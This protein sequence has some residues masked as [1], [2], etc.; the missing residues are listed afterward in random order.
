MGT[1]LS[2]PELLITPL[3]PGRVAPVAACPVSPCCCVCILS[4]I[5]LLH[6]SVCLLGPHVTLSTRVIPSLCTPVLLADSSSDRQ[7]QPHALLSVRGWTRRA[8][9]GQALQG[10]MRAAPP[11]RMSVAHVRWR[12]AGSLCFEPR[13]GVRVVAVDLTCAVRGG[14]VTSLS[15]PPRPPRPV[16]VINSEAL[17]EVSEPWDCKQLPTPSRRP[18]RCS[19]RSAAQ[20]C[21]GRLGAP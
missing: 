7:T 6:D 3:P 2:G 16:F 1:T 10:V 4:A 13:G 14:I 9:R 21:G 15:S 19:C 17:A 20:T 11:L 5:R 12:A 8:S 18:R